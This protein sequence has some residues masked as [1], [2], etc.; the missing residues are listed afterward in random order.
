[1]DRRPDRSP[2]ED[3][4][5]L[6]RNVGDKLRGLFG[7]GNSGPGGGGNGPSA[8]G[9]GAPSIPIGRFLPIIIILA[10]IG[11]LATGIYTIQ[12]GEAGVVRTFGSYSGPPTGAGL[13]YHFPAPIQSVEVVDTQT[14]RRTEIG[15]RT[16][17][18]QSNNEVAGKRSNLAEAL[19]LTSDENIVQVELLVQY[20]IADAADFVFNVQNPE[21]V[22][23]TSAEVALRSAVGNMTIDAVITEERG[24]VQMDTKANLERLLAEYNIGID[25]GEVLLQVADPPEEVRDAFQEVVRARADKERLINEAQA[26]QND[27]V[28]RAAG[29]A[30]ELINTAKAFEAA[31]IAEAEGEADRFLAFIAGLAGSAGQD[32]LAD[33]LDA[34]EDTSDLAEVDRESARKTARS[35]FLA[36]LEG[37]DKDPSYINRRDVMSE[38]LYLETMERILPFAKKFILTPDSGGNLLQFLPLEGNSASVAPIVTTQ[39]DSVSEE[40]K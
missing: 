24:K 31:R 8:G 14:V 23:R 2:E 38:R 18:D 5:Q 34:L 33:Y 36:S 26:Y 32:A 37:L 22:L 9:G 35:Q 6:V 13:N 7:G 28:P 1:M 25:V 27:I 3:F 21:S 11:W 12:P 10:L 20:R 19:M 17:S 30:E 40:N 16:D 29:Q 4:E 39:D 15:F